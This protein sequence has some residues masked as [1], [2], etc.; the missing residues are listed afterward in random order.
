MKYQKH[1]HR[2]SCLQSTLSIWDTLYNYYYY[3]YWV[4]SYIQGL[5]G[6][7]GFAVF[8]GGGTLLLSFLSREIKGEFYTD[9]KG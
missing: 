7:G 9:R 5:A 4:V 2:I 8:V 3:Y 1:G 6:R